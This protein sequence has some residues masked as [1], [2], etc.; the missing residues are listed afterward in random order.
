MNETGTSTVVWTLRRSARTRRLWITVQRDGSV[1]VTAPHRE[2]LPA[3]ERFVREKA[4]WIARTVAH[5]ARYKDDVLLPR[6]RRSYLRH[7][8]TARAIVHGWLAKYAPLVGLP[9]GRVFIKNLRRN[10]GSCSEAGNLNFN[11]KLALLPERLSEYVVLHE[12][13]HLAHFDHSP[14]FWK[15]VVRLMPDAKLRRKEMRKYHA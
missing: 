3:I 14:A 2:P 1:V 5:V 6:D 12:L 8:E 9:Y 15:L 7:R 4:A 11:Y 13:C 10:W